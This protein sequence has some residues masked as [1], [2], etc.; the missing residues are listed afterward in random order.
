MR[1]AGRLRRRDA[2]PPGLRPAILPTLPISPSMDPT[3]DRS[4]VPP[5]RLTRAGS[6]SVGCRVTHAD[7]ERLAELARRRGVP[8]GAV[9]RCLLLVE[10]DGADVG[11]IPA[12]SAT[13]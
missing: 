13:T 7:A 11:T 8:P 1:N 9:L 12:L 6:R 4:P 10:L 3:A 2:L 5:P